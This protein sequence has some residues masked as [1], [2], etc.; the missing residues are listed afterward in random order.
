MWLLRVI[1]KDIQLLINLRPWVKVAGLILAIALLA[2]AWRAGL[3]LDWWL[4]PQRFTYKNVE[5]FASPLK[6]VVVYVGILLI[7]YIVVAKD[8]DRT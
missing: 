2:L 3:D 7:I 4:T 6:E 1:R 5:H 8:R